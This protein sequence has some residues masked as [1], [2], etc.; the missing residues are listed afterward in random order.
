MSWSNPFQRTPEWFHQRRGKLS[1]SRIHR[2]ISGTPRGWATLAAEL[3]YEESAEFEQVEISTPSIDNGKIYEPVAIANAE[4][5]LGEEFE[6]VGFVTHPEYEFLGCSSDFLARGRTYNGEVKCPLLLEKHMMVQQFR[7]LPKEYYPQV[8]CQMAVHDIRTT[9]FISYYSG[10]KKLPTS[11]RTAIIEVDRDDQYIE[12]MYRR[13]ITFQ[14]YRNG[15]QEITP[16]RRLTEL[17]K[18][19]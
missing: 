6:P 1:A 13:C 12:E 5:E 18:L 2:V 8:Q 9:L 15:L 14:Q 11:M 7:Q 10:N 19:F 16:V 3:A 4:L 17:P